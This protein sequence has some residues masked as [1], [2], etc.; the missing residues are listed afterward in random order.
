MAKRRPVRIDEITRLKLFQ[1]TSS[2]ICPGQVF[3]GINSY[4]FFVGFFDAL[5]LFDWGSVREL[6]AFHVLLDCSGLEELC[7]SSVE[8]FFALFFFFVFVGF[9]DNF[10]DVSVWCSDRCTDCCRPEFTVGYVLRVAVYRA[11]VDF[12]EV[13]FGIGQICDYEAAFTRS[14]LKDVVHYFAFMAVN[15]RHFSSQDLL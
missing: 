9:V 2:R 8:K 1:Q 4:W 3:I 5:A 12:R 15:V 14:P 13:R 11:E 7:P 10:L 6:V